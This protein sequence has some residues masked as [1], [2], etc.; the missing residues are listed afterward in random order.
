MKIY[1]NVTE[2]D[3]PGKSKK[4][5][6]S[7]TNVEKGKGKSQSEVELGFERGKSKSTYKPASAET[8]HPAYGKPGAGSKVRSLLDKARSAKVDIAHDDEGKPYRAGYTTAEKEPDK[9]TVKLNVKPSIPDRINPPSGN[10]T[11]IATKSAA[12][13]KKKPGKL[14]AMAMTY[15]T[16]SPSKGGGTMYKK[17]VSAR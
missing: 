12:V 13:V 8:G 17:K 7:S 9:F 3:T 5:K 14:K 4:K 6:S 16:D 1:S 11:P 10:K 2:D 15:G